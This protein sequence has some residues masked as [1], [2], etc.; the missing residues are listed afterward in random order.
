MALSFPPPSSLFPHFVIGFSGPAVPQELSV[1]EHVCT[2]MVLIRM[3][4]LPLRPLTV[5]LLVFFFL[6][7]LLLHLVS[8]VTPGVELDPIFFSVFV[9]LEDDW[10]TKTYLL[11]QR[12]LFPLTTASLSQSSW[13]WSWLCLSLIIQQLCSG[14]AP[15]NLQ[16][17]W[18]T[19]GSYT[20]PLLCSYVRLDSETQPVCWPQTWVSYIILTFVMCCWSWLFETS[21]SGTWESA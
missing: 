1:W 6:W 20:L 21:L 8:V 11:L 4:L 3:P 18:M 9:L 16:L 15:L 10:S 14:L 2:N 13:I 17:P 19:H 5:G 12:I 7:N